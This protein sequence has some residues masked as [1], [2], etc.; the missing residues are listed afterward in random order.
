ML[1]QIGKGAPPSSDDWLYEVKWDG[2]RALC[3]IEDGKLRM[4]SRNGNSIDR[5]YPELS[6]LPHHIKADTAILDGEIAALD[7]RGVPSFEMLQRRITS[8][9]R[10]P[11]RCSRAKSPSSFSLS[12]CS[13]SMAA[14]CAAPL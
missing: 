8:L 1:A 5:Q 14:I 10:A 9:R 4:V 11:S 6:I 3:Y 12:I 13:I 2:V 7:A